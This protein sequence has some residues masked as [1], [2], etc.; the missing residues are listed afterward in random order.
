MHATLLLTL[1]TVLMLPLTLFTLLL[2]TLRRQ[3][4]FDAAV[5]VYDMAMLRCRHTCFRRLFTS[6]Y[7]LMLMLL[8]CRRVFR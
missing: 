2:Y 1:I 8:R 4:L 3:L 6:R 7:A 5:Y